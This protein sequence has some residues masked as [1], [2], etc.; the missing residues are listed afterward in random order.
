MSLVKWT[1][2]MAGTAMT[3]R[4]LSNRHRQRLE[5]GNDS[6]P[7]ADRDD[8]GQR[9]RDSASLAMRSGQ[10]SSGLSDG[11]A[12]GANGMG[13][14]SNIGMGTGLGSGTDRFGA[15]AGSADDDFSSPARTGFKGTPFTPI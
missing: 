14:G 12:R 3:V 8:A 11:A 1:L 13:I 2:A 7:E 10:A 9:D 5:K 15:S 6:K 4:Y